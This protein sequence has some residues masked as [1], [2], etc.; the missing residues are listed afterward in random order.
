MHLVVHRLVVVSTSGGEPSWCSQFAGRAGIS[1]IETYGSKSK[2]KQC[3]WWCVVL[4]LQCRLKITNE[5][6]RFIEVDHCV[7]V[8][9]N[10]LEKTSEAIKVAKSKFNKQTN[11]RPTVREGVRDLTLREGEV[12]K[13]RSFS[14]TASAGASRWGPALED[15]DWHTICQTILKGVEGEE[16]WLFQGCGQ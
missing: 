16:W 11:E 10:N 8:K 15:E 13:L 3:I 9:M 2:K 5:L 12:G 14:N 4:Q 7:V 6:M 1:I